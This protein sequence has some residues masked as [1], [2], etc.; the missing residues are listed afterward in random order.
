MIRRAFYILT[1]TVAILFASC[2]KYDHAIAD[3]EDRLDKIEGTSLTT[4]D[5][6]ITAINASLDDLKAVDT[7]LQTLIDDLES[8]AA[9]LQQQLDDNAAADAATK[10]ALEDE[11]ANI[12]AL[13]AELQKKDAELDQRIADLQT[14]VDSE[15]TATED[16]ANATFATLTQYEGVQT[17]IA[18]IKALIEQHKTDITAEYTKAIEDAIS[19]SETSMKTWVNELLADGYYDI[20]AID[21]KLAALESKLTDADA[22]LKKQI[23]D[24]QAAL[25]QA[26]KDLTA[27]YEKAIADAIETNNGTIDAAIAKA[28][29]DALDKVD[30]RLAVIDNAIAAI[31]K[32]IEG[33]KNSIATIK[34]QIENINSSIEDLKGVDAELGDYINA[35]E[36][37]A[38]DLQKQ[39]D[40]TNTKIGNV[41]SEMGE[42]ID[43]LE[44]S[45][46]NELNNLKSTLEGELAVISAD[47]AS[48]KAKDAELEN[49]ISVLENYVQS[50]LQGYQDWANATFATLEQY[51][52]IQASIAGIEADIKSINDAM[53]ALETRINDKIATDIKSAIDALRTE[54]GADYAAK[55]QT[56][57]ND[58]TGAYTAAIAA[59]KSE[60][61]AAYNKAIKDAIAECETSMKSWVNE[62][63]QK[64]YEEIADLEAQLS[65]L[66]AG[67]VSDQEL[68]DAIAEQ[69]A[70]LE[71]AKSELADAYQKAIQDAV[72]NGGI[73]SNTILSIVETV[74]NALLEQINNIADRVDALE[75]KLEDI[76]GR[77]QS[78]TFI[79]Q[80]SDGKVKM[81]YESCETVLDFIVS[82]A[83]LL[84]NLNDAFSVNKGIIKAYVR[85]TSDPVTRVVSAAYLQTV[86]EMIVKED[87]LFT[88]TVS[89]TNLDEKFWS[90]DVEAV[91]YIQISIDSSEFVSEAIPMVAHGYVG[92]K[93]NN[94]SDFENGDDYTGEASE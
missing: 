30:T 75:S 38:A 85:Y 7:A 82:P 52:E 90:G 86:S 43:A 28:V 66:A 77:I 88:L 55:I 20:A 67:G 8:E 36:A 35:L 31:Q 32:D 17:E 65:E 24:Q 42:E 11:I 78:L 89:G 18:A 51:S 84:Q 2:E 64:V 27:A 41:K 54:L 34:E 81:D 6:Q 56:A 50:E 93:E 4:I 29:Q 48:L 9:N 87:G 70:A 76:V 53:A 45:L 57:V 22:E 49:R 40:D 21:A 5:Q 79:P 60:I 12:K 37:A 26:K 71:Q 59:A 3:I 47:I 58:V 23:E 63:L 16:W 14:Y 61:E 94:I 72:A 39:L 69:Q 46:L 74:Q 73:I 83:E 13:I 92:N 44:Q 33:I 19:T 25:E 80:Y 15:I 68:A 91:I 1:A 62:E 10:K